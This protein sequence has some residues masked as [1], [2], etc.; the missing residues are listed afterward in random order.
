MFYICSD[1]EDLEGPQLLKALNL[2]FLFYMLVKW[3]GLGN[4]IRFSISCAVALNYIIQG[5]FV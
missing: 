4:D 3:R 2:S 1:C 5:A